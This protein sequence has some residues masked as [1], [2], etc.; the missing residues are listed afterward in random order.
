MINGRSIAY[1]CN[2]HPAWCG[3]LYLAMLIVLISVSIFFLTG[4]VEQH[5]SRNA[6]LDRLAHIELRMNRAARHD[7]LDSTPA[8]SPLLEAGTATLASASLLQRVS[9]AVKSSG[10]VIVSTEVQSQQPQAKDNLLKVAIH[11]DLA[12]HMLQPLL[13]DLEA[14]MPFLFIDQLTVQALSAPADA[15]R[16]QVRLVVAGLWAGGE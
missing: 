8:G 12:E 16:L 5:Q 15:G 10:G 3:A 14:G 1:A 7:A 2:H 6:T 13:Y 11:C 9:T 4:V